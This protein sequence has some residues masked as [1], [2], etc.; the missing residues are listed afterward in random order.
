MKKVTTT[1]F[2]S[3]D[4]KLFINAEECERYE[5]DNFARRLVGL[6]L[7]QVVD[8]FDGRDPELA[9]AFRKAGARVRAP[10][11]AGK[12][13]IPAPPA[14]SDCVEAPGAETLD[15]MLNEAAAIEAGFT[16][17]SFE[18]RDGVE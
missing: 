3:F 10:R 8:A 17:V 15:D 5:G 14:A 13:Q 18:D 9:S 4:G 6:T 16:R 12:A 11:G 7:Q 2:S 1:V